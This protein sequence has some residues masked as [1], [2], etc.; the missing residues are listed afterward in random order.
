VSRPIERVLTAW[1]G[2]VED[3][4]AL[5]SYARDLDYG[6]G[7]CTPDYVAGEVLA[8]CRANLDEDGLAIEEEAERFLRAEIIASGEAHNRTGGAS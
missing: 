8:A 5:R 2:D 3:C 6:P 7:P 1:V 4:A